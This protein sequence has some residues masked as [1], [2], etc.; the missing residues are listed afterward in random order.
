MKIKTQ[1]LEITEFTIDMAK[2]VHLNSLDDDNREFNPNEVFE[3]IEDATDTV[4]FLMGVYENGDGPLVYPVLLSDGTN[5]GYVQAVP[6]DNDEWEIGYHIAKAYAGK[7]YAT[8]AVKAFMPVVMK[9]LGITEILGI[10]VVENVASI[11]VL[12]K[13]GFEKLYEGMGAYQDEE[14]AIC[15][16]VYKLND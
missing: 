1:R 15:K 3:T 8:E 12:E 16:Y 13:T 9:E 4:E 10:C 5:I 7:G 14:R 11:K 2:D 6:M